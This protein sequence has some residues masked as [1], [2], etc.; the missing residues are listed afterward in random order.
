MRRLVCGAVAPW[1]AVTLAEAL[2]AKLFEKAKYVGQR[3]E[4]GSGVEYVTYRMANA[5]SE[6]SPVYA[7]LEFSAKEMGPMFDKFVSEGLMPPGLVVCVSP[8]FLP[9]E[10]DSGSRWYLRGEEFDQP[11]AEYAAFLTKELLPAAAK[12]A[13]VTLTDDPNL[14]F[15]A[16]GSSGGAAAWHLVWYGKD[17]FRRAYLASPTFSDVRGA[18]IAPY[19]IR[20][21][22]SKPVRVYITLGDIEPDRS[23]GDSFAVG[24]AARGSFDYAGYPCRM[25]YFPE[26]GHLAG[27]S[28]EAVM[29]RMI[30]FT[31]RGWRE[32]PVKPT[33][34][35]LRV[36]E[37]IKAGTTWEKYAGEF[38]APVEVKGSKGKYVVEGG[39]IVF[40]AKDGS[41][42]VVYEGKGKVTAVTF[43]K[44]DGRL[45]A[46]DLGRRFVLSFN[47]RKD[48]TLAAVYR[49]SPLTLPVDPTIV[50]AY[51]LCYLAGCDRMLAA[52][53]LGIQG[54]HHFGATDVIIPLPDDLPATRVAVRDGWLY[55]ASGAR[56]WRRPLNPNPPKQD[57]TAYACEGEHRSTPH[58]PFFRGAI[59]KK[60]VI[61]DNFFDSPTGKSMQV[62]VPKGDAAAQAAANGDF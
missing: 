2:P 48:G 29:R 49:H 34:N 13:G 54:A 30:E 35:P 47:V 3:Y 27:K 45:F 44:D 37:V 26:G 4:P 32:G 55:A 41:R 33:R 56:Q 52:T 23:F 18:E 39:K 9:P 15:V 42:K 62:P 57:T 7:L 24:L 19:L 1:G 53:E 6:N 10:I 17:Y 16:G 38:P 5:P 21:T 36:D 50:G 11:S 12:A 14:H 25:E 40:V 46:T 58:L 8:G 59:G 61:L 22:E 31:W 43:G 51:D 60:S 20:K 28:S